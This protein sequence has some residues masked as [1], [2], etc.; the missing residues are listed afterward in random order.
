MVKATEN[1]L[2]VILPFHNAPLDITP[3]AVDTNRELVVLDTVSPN[4]KP[5]FIAVQA[6][7][8]AHARW[9]SHDGLQIRGGRRMTISCLRRKTVLTKI[10][11]AG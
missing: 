6:S 11:R 10:F 8:A 3:F 9:F 1:E 7:S 5:V 4:I 2:A